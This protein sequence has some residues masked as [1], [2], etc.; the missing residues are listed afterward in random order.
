VTDQ[1]FQ[2]FLQNH[3]QQM[4]QVQDRVLRLQQSVAALQAESVLRMDGKTPR[5]TVEFTAQYGEDLFAWAL[6]GRQTKGFF[7]EAGAFDGYRYSVTYG[8]EAMGWN[9]LLVEAIPER[10]RQCVPRRPNSRV[11]N[12]V[13]SP[14]GAVGDAELWVV[15][16]QYG[17]MHSYTTLTPQR[18]Q[19]LGNIPRTPI[20]VPRSTLDGLLADHEGAIDLVV[21]DLEG[22]EI[23]AL[24][25]FDLARF[26][27]RVLMIEDNTGGQELKDFMQKHEYS[28]VARV[29]VNEIYIRRDE[30]QLLEALKWIM[31]QGI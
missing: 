12:A 10:C 25:G 14:N 27:P 11:V 19:D 16:D 15:Q 3:R 2:Q 24:N 4:K 5:M 21:L 31:L 26:R 30:A 1:D 18:A 7:V 6:F 8:L 28:L 29:A 13:L 17:G 23:P 22:D 20:A 9:G